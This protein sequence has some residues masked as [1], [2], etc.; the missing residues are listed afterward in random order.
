M[1]LSID[2]REKIV[3]MLLLLT[4]QS[5]LAGEFIIMMLPIFGQNHA[6]ALP[7]PFMIAQTTFFLPLNVIV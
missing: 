4:C 7:S 3:Y 1:Y 5:M 2:Q 6:Q